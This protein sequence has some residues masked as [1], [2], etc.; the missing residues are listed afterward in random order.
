MHFPITETSAAPKATT[1][2]D[3]SCSTFCT[4]SRT[5]STYCSSPPVLHCRAHTVQDDVAKEENNN[6]N[7]INKNNN[8]MNVFLNGV[9]ESLG[10]V[11]G[12][13]RAVHNT[14]S[15]FKFLEKDDHKNDI[16]CAKKD[17]QQDQQQQHLEDD[18]DPTESCSDTSSC[19]SF[20]DDDL[21][22]MMIDEDGQAKQQQQ[23]RPMVKPMKRKVLFG[24]VFVR[25]YASTVGDHPLCSDSCPLTLD[26]SYFEIMERD[27]ESFESKRCLLR[28]KAPRRLNIDQRRDRIKETGSVDPTSLQEM[29]FHLSMSR[30]HEPSGHDEE[31]EIEEVIE[32]EDDDDE[33]TVDECMDG[34]DIYSYPLEIQQDCILTEDGNNE[35]EQQRQQIETII[36]K[37]VLPSPTSYKEDSSQQRITAV[38]V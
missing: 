1:S 33:Y 13:N 37:R 9:A 35:G 17:Q 16:S 18:C 6:I 29:E 31:E 2:I 24:S 15:T 36:W 26:W 32:E 19:C 5:S 34:N 28:H 11:F 12:R 14:K 22:E 21:D 4:S 10:D 38:W 23:Q 20:Y 27:L 8:T 7:D 30:L 25:E 3:C